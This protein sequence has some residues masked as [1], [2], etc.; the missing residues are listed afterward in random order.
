MN[1]S[2]SFINI[3]A[4]RNKMASMSGKRSEFSTS[5]KYLI[6]GRFFII[7]FW[8]TIHREILTSGRMSADF[9]DVITTAVRRVNFIKNVALNTIIFH[10]L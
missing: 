8:C 5:T 9:I 7:L 1:S 3:T 2:V 6:S 4:R 10:L